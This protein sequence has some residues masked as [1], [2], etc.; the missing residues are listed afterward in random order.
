MVQLWQENEMMWHGVSR[1]RVVITLIFAF[2]LLG[3][4]FGCKFPGSSSNVSEATS[5]DRLGKSNDPNALPDSGPALPP[6]IAYLVPL[7]GNLVVAKAIGANKV[8]VTGLRGSADPRAVQVCS[9]NQTLG[10]ISPDC[11]TITNGSF[12]YLTTGSVGDKISIWEK[13]PQYPDSSPIIEEVLLIQPQ[14]SPKQ[15]LGFARSENGLFIQYAGGKLI[16]FPK[17]EWLK[18]LDQIQTIDLSK[19]LPSNNVMF[20]AEDDQGGVWVSD[21][22]QIAHFVKKGSSV[23]LSKIYTLFDHPE[24]IALKVHPVGNIL[25]LVTS[26]ELIRAD[27]PN[28]PDNDPVLTHFS[29]GPMT[30]QFISAL[31]PNPLEAQGFWVACS[32]NGLFYF[33][34]AINGSEIEEYPGRGTKITSLARSNDGGS[35]YFGAKEN[36]SRQT[37]NSTSSG[38]NTGSGSISAGGGGDATYYG[39]LHQVTLPNGHP[40]ADRSQ[41]EDYTVTHLLLNISGQN[42][43]DVT[44]LYNPGTGGMFVGTTHGLVVIDNLNDP[45]GS[46][47]HPDPTFVGTQNPIYAISYEPSERSIWLGEEYEGVEFDEQGNPIA[48]FR[49][50]DIANDVWT[51]FASWRMVD[52]HANAIAGNGNEIVV[53]TESGGANQFLPPSPSMPNGTMTSLYPLGSEISSK[54]SALGYDHLRRLWIGL[55]GSL[56]EHNGHAIRELDGTLRLLPPPVVSTS[57]DSYLLDANPNAFVA[58]GTDSMWEL[59]GGMGGNSI[60][61]VHN[62]G[63]FELLAPGHPEP[64][65]D[66]YVSQYAV[67]TTDGAGGVFL[68]NGSGFYPI[69]SGESP[70]GVPITELFHITF[71]TGTRKFEIHSLGMIEAG[72]EN[73]YGALGRMMFDGASLWIGTM[74]MQIYRID[75]VDGLSVSS[76]DHVAPG[77]LVRF[78][79]PTGDLNQLPIKVETLTDQESVA[80]TSDGRG[81]VFI[82]ESAD[83]VAYHGTGILHVQK[84]SDGTFST[85]H[86]ST[87]MRVDENYSLM[88]WVPS[89]SSLAIGYLDNGFALLPYRF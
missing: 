26:S 53:G 20:M 63:S 57:W 40:V 5:Q 32:T 16:F 66:F 89:L 56:S 13:A 9:V 58:A 28:G 59:A 7:D 81:G 52:W 45:D 42:T 68:A 43:V 14:F 44:S 23:A 30:L 25:W 21:Q 85:Q 51:Y 24:I 10:Q 73:V 48:R 88:T 34:G 87:P 61:Y 71:H 78:V 22:Q 75:M 11:S 3:D 65:N 15:I 29:Q 12:N 74:K 6:P 62:D 37:I 27:F 72:V 2:S 1:M 8:L 47:Y 79:F 70:E 64:E 41:G 50:Y 84:N 76:L 82:N 18:S 39:G 55:K 19:E 36:M 38:G 67:M 83:N 69:G 86:L 46:S 35:I 77:G 49:K 80:L 17:G 4:I 60:R 54:V 31:L 33:K